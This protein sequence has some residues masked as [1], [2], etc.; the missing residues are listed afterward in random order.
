[1][2]VYVFEVHCSNGFCEFDSRTTTIKYKI[3]KN[4][5]KYKNGIRVDMMGNYHG[6]CKKSC[7]QNTIGFPTK[8]GISNN[9]KI[10]IKI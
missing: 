2:N 1:M 6:G 8:K 9:C 7:C 10:K 4:Y 3:M 5:I